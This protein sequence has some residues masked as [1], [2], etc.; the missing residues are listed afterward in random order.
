[1]KVLD[2]VFDPDLVRLQEAIQFVSCA[3]TEKPPQFGLRNAPASVFFQSDCFQCPARQVA[4][5]GR[6]PVS[7]VVGNFESNAYRAPFRLSVPV[8]LVQPHPSAAAH[9]SHS[10]L[11]NK[12]T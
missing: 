11:P 5:S 3:E 9:R 8:S 4:A 6:W 12:I 1:V 7:Q 10:L 2:V